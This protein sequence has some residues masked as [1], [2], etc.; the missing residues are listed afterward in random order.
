MSAP[1]DGTGT[2][3]AGTG[4]TESGTATRERGVV[5]SDSRWW[6][7]VAALPAVVAL[8][9]ATSVWVLFGVSLEFTGG[10]LFGDAQSLVLLPAVALGIPAV[11]VFLVLPI[12]L[13]RDG[14]ATLR[15]G[16]GWPDLPALWAGAAG[17]VDVVLLVG[18][19]LLAHVD[20]TLGFG[21]IAVA[22]ISGTIL[23]V[24]YLRARI[25]NVWT[26]TTI[27]ELKRELQA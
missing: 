1:E 12:A 13:W 17:I 2:G 19:V 16:A 25:Q 5:H 26:P 4:T 21:V 11:V 7:W 18:L 20:A 24:V 10:D 15:A 22:V 27:G 9:T 23:A 3:D 8:W 6:Y 14:E